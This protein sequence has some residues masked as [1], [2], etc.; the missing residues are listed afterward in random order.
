MQ[1]NEMIYLQ[2]KT[3]DKLK[4]QKLEQMISDNPQNTQFTQQFLQQQ[5]DKNSIQKQGTLL[6]QNELSQAI[7]KFHQYISKNQHINSIQTQQQSQE[8][9]NLQ[10]NPK[11]KTI[12]FDTN[13][14]NVQPKHSYKVAQDL[15]TK[16]DNKTHSQH[17]R[18][19]SNIIRNNGI[20]NRQIVNSKPITPKCGT[21]QFT[22]YS[23]IQQEQ[24]TR[25]EEEIYYIQKVKQA[26]LLQD[27]NDYL[28]KVYRNHFK[29]LCQELSIG[30]KL[31]PANYIDINKK[32]LKLSQQNKY[33][34]SITLVFDL[35]ETLIHCNQR[36]QKSYDVILT[37]NL[38][39]TQQVFAKINIRPNA[40]EILK[41][42]SKDFELIVF[43]ASDQIYA[44]SIID[45]L[46]PNN[47]IFA[48]RLYRESCI[49]TSGGI[50]VKDLRIL[51][52]NLERVALIDNSAFNFSQQIDNG[53][54]IIPFFDNKSDDELKKLYKYLSGMKEWYD[55]REYNRKHLQLY[56]Y[57]QNIQNLKR[58]QQQIDII[59]D[60]D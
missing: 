32:G 7:K 51:N 53:I 4:N 37:I 44:K 50:L 36:D 3:G 31:K 41:K 43:T 40:V 16:S 56:R 34:D 19:T 47:N 52:R 35:D 48:H 60:Q 8:T 29:Q 42:L 18:Q 2:Q 26:I 27:Q 30:I 39:K 38:N 57:T 9:Q 59:E 1:Q 33:K 25:N 13:F 54:P 55:V 21:F 10:D 11:S 45:Y 23:Y 5:L 6:T 15:S 20:V 58:L 17:F 24:T 12:N 46:D 28:N 49:L 14:F 22:Q